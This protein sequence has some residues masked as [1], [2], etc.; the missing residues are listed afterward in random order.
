VQAEVLM[1]MIDEGKLT[2]PGE[3][4]TPAQCAHGRFQS[5]LIA[6]N[7]AGEDV[8]MMIAGAEVAYQE[9]AK[10]A[11]EAGHALVYDGSN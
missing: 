4:P 3:G 11:I 2:K 8:A 9:T 1:H 10:I 5:T 6:Y 7:E